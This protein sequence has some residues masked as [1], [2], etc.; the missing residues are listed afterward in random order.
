MRRKNTRGRS[1]CVR[2]QKDR[3]RVFLEENMLNNRFYKLTSAIIAAGTLLFSDAAFADNTEIIIQAHTGAALFAPENTAAA[4]EKAAELGATGIETDLRMTKDLEIVIHHD[5]EIDLTSNGKGIISEMTLSELKELDFG[6]WFS[7]EYAGEHILTLEEF[8]AEA[9]ELGF[10]SV[11]LEL[12]PTLI[13]DEDG[14]VADGSKVYVETAANIIRESGYIDHI[15]VTSFDKE[16][17]KIM[18]EYAPE[19]QVGILTIPNLS[20]L[21]LFNLSQFFPADK[22]LAD[23]EPE[24]VENVPEPVIKLMES[25]GAKG[26]THTELLLELL[27]GVGAATPSG[28]TWSELEI[29]IAEQADIAAYVESLDFQ[30]EYVN[31]HFNSLTKELI[32]AMHADGIGVFAWTPDETWELSKVLKLSPDGIVTNRPDT[33]LSMI[34]E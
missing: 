11:N 8:L 33:A 4:F 19:V 29:L 21:S 23:Y 31:C 14:N 12:K 32:Y 20:A 22:A 13:K 1:F 17:L 3:P 5:D 24:D 2:T 25:F 9:R 34:E 16:L 27:H 10:E 26:K 18:K 7:P 28:T 6:S 30:V 15:M